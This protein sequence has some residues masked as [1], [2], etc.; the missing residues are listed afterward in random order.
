MQMRCRQRRT[1]RRKA[2]R[3]AKAL[4]EEHTHKEAVAEPGEDAA[5]PTE[6]SDEEATLTV[7]HQR[8]GT[9]HASPAQQEHDGAESGSRSVK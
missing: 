3:E 7:T 5:T 1:A 9:A 8:P 4:A 6:L 2:E